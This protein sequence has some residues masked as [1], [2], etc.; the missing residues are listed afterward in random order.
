[1]DAFQ[2][3]S[4][5]V[6]LRDQ[7]GTGGGGQADREASWDDLP[8]TAGGGVDPG[9]R[10]SDLN[11]RVGRWA[12]DPDRPAADSH[13]LG[14]EV[15]PNGPKQP[16]GGRIDPRHAIA[17]RSDPDAAAGDRDARGTLREE[18]DHRDHA[19]AGQVDAGHR[20][21]TG[22]NPSGIRAD[23]HQRRQEAAI[24]GRDLERQLIE[25]DPGHDPAGPGVKP[26][27]LI[28][29]GVRH[30]DRSCA[31]RQ[32]GRIRPPGW[33]AGD[34]SVGARIDPHD[35]AVS[36]RADPQAAGVEHQRA[37]AMADLD[38]GCR[39][40]IRQ[41]AMLR[42]R[43]CCGG[44]RLRPWRRLLGAGDAPQDGEHCDRP[45]HSGPDS[46]PVTL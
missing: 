12:T 13:L 23:R 10:T 45:E 14:V 8:D 36:P 9:H 34:D 3:P 39:P 40:A 27:H 17:T 37:T 33:E 7:D 41:G 43:R 19:V 22:G 15:E 38:L 46:Q 35:L 11:N 21:A 5:S 4:N 25:L 16:V 42:R 18:L 6:R 31:D 30:P 20:T 28:G 2:R 29:V 26:H 24:T 1:M 32:A 44:R